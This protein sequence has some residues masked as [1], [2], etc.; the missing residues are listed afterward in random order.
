LRAVRVAAALALA[1]AL[2]ATLARVLGGARLSIDLVLIAVIYVA[3]SAGSAAGLI[4]G[5][6]G[7]LVQDTLAATGTSLV[8]AGSG[9]VAVTSVIGVGGLAK[10]VVGFF[11]GIIGTQFIVTR[12]MSRFL[13]F[14]AASLVHGAIF[15]GLYTILDP[16]Y[17]SVSYR[18]IVNQAAGNAV[19]GVLVFQALGFVPGFVERRWSG[20]GRMKINRPRR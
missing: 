4:A 14:F 18:S 12:P 5:A 16:R 10:T 20:R 13:V 3:L 1:L 15:F 17:G 8:A 19:I 6:L 2:Q 11:S 9:V 7:G